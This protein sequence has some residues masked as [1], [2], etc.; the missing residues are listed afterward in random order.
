MFPDE[1][2]WSSD[3]RLLH[4]LTPLIRAEHFAAVDRAKLLIS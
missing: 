2:E 4:L 3:L 1:M